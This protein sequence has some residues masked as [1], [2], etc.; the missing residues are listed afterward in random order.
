MTCGLEF[1]IHN[2]A[3]SLVS[4]PLYSNGTQLIF[5]PT[6]LMCGTLV[7]MRTFDILIS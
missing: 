1:R 7:L 2:E 5:L 6:I 3:V 4:T